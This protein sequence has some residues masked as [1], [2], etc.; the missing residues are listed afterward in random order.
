MQTITSP[1]KP[2]KK[3]RPVW[4]VSGNVFGL[5]EFFR[6]IGG[7]KFR[8]SWSFFSDP[9]DEICEELKTNGRKSFAEQVEYSLERKEAKAERYEAYAENAHTKATDRQNKVEKIMSFIPPGQPILVGHH[10]EKRHRK[11]IERMDSNMRRSVEETEKADYFTNKSASLRH[12][13]K[14]ITCS[15]K[16][17]G[18]RI[19]DATKDI[20]KLNRYLS[21]TQNKANKIIYAERLNQAQEKLAF[22]TNQLKTLEQSQFEDEAQVPSP[23]NIKVGD[24][25]YYLGWHPVVRVNKKTVTVSHWHDTPQ[26]R[27]SL[28]YTKIQKFRSKNTTC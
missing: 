1:T 11:D 7:R 20:A 14:H 17:I 27:Y 13:A 22:W 18:N 19:A 25:V 24:E 2:G 21:L 10:S 5:E 12:D 9:T 3:P 4:V 23:E 16:F 15:R 26:S 6:S 8:G 28:P